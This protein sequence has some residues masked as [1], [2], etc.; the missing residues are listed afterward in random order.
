V[1]IGA[2]GDCDGQI[3]VTDDLVGMF[4]GFKP[5]FVKRYAELGADLAQAAARY[6]EDVRARRFPEPEQCFRSKAPRAVE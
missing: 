5:K 3:L 1:G 6:A 4:T 2:S